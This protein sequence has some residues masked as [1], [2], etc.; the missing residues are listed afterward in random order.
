MVWPTLG[1]IP[2][3]I[4]NGFR[5][6]GIIFLSLA[7]VWQLYSTWLLLFIITV[8]TD[9]AACNAKPLTSIEC[10]LVFV[11]MAIGVALCFPKMNSIA[12]VSLH[13]AVTAIVYCTMDWTPAIAKGR[14]RDVSYNPP[15]EETLVATYGGILN[16]LGVIFLAFRGHIVILEIQG[17]LPTSPKYSSHRRMWSGVT[18]AYYLLIAICMFPLAMVGFW[19][20]GNKVRPHSVFFSTSKDISNCHLVSRSIDILFHL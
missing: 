9:G 7:F 16:A 13:G 20:Y 12:R 3:T 18:M 1:L 5:V 8:C 10:Y 14:P 15:P 2:I 19:A 6:W 4:S 17:T 11:C